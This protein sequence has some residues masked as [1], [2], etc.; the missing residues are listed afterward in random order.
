MEVMKK[1]RELADEIKKTQEYI[2]M[3]ATQETVDDDDF[4]SALM[5]DMNLLQHE[6]IKSAHEGADEAALK[7]IEDLLED[8]HAEL[9][10]YEPTAR[11]IRA[12]SAFDKLVE[13]INNEISDGITGGCGEDG[14]SGCSGCK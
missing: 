12:K 6:Y 4:G 5:Q 9:M 10:D 13:A 7:M 1:A 3:I 2:M 14:C 11:L 8:K